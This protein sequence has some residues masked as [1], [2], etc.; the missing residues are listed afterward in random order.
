MGISHSIHR[1]AGFFAC[2]WLLECTNNSEESSLVQ[3]LISK[4]FIKLMQSVFLDHKL[5]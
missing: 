4:G 2:K 1:S 5:P 3:N